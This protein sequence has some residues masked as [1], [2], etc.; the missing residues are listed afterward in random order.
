MTVAAIVILSAM[1]GGITG[2]AVVV[3]YDHSA[4]KRIIELQRVVKDV[5]NGYYDQDINAKKE[6]K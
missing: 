6:E 4:R 2:A 1:I 5:E 3:A